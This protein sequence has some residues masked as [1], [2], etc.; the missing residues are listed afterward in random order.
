MRLEIACAS[1]RRPF[2]ALEHAGLVRCA[3]CEERHG[4]SLPAAGATVTVVDTPGE[5]WA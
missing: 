2:D 5:A 4:F 3:P 1:C